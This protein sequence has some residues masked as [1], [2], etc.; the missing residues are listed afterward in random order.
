MNAAELGRVFVPIRGGDAVGV[1]DDLPEWVRD[2][3]RDAVMECHGDL[4]PDDMVYELCADVWAWLAEHV[5]YAD[6]PDTDDAAHMCADYLVGGSWCFY[7]DQHRWLLG[8]PYARE[9][10]DDSVELLQTDGMAATITGGLYLRFRE[11][12]EVLGRVMAEL[13]VVDAERVGGGA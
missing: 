13:L 2:T 12:A 5:E 1:S 4:L 6:V 3:V 7:Y 11:I 8:D 10:C 9:Y